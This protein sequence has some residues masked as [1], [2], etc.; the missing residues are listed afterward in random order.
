MWNRARRGQLT[1]K[2]VRDGSL[3]YIYLQNEDDIKE[4]LFDLKQD[5]AEKNNLLSERKEDVKRLK[6]LLKKWED[7]VEH[8]R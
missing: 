5:P 4:Y 2:A 8:K 7:K 3:K 6:M 1:R